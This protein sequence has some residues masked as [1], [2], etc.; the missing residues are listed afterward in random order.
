[1]VCGTSKDCKGVLFLHTEEPLKYTQGCWIKGNVVSLPYLIFKWILAVILVSNNILT[2]VKY[3]WNGKY[4]TYATNWGHVLLSLSLTID[5]ILVLVRFTMQNRTRNGSPHYENCHFTLRLSR[6]LTALAY[7][8]VLSVTVIYYTALFDFSRDIFAYLKTMD[9]YV[10]IFVHFITTVIALIDTMVSSRPWCIW[11]AWFVTLCGLLYMVF[12]ATY[13]LVFNGTNFDGTQDYVYSILDWKSD[14]IGDK[15]TC[16]ILIIGVAV[17][18]PM[19]H[20]TF[21]LIAALRDSCWKRIQ[22]D[23]VEDSDIYVMV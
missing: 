1:M 9:G 2:L 19:A 4:W 3:W 5:A 11:H 23:P 13:I 22:G 12:N 21:Y 15:I 20:L 18:F 16:L 8:W 7:P 10:D 14:Q 6:A 17:G